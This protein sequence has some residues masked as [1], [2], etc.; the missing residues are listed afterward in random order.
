MSKVAIV[1]DSSAYIPE[2]LLEQYNISVAPLVVIWGEDEYLDNVDIQP[3]EL[4]ERLNNSDVMPSTSQATP[5]SFMEAY[6]PLYEQGY[7]IL[8]IHLSEKL[9]GTIPSAVQAKGMLP[10]DATIEIIDSYTIAM[11]LGYQVLLVARAVTDGAS[12][13]ECKEIVLKARSMCGV[14][15]AVD[16]L[17]FLHRGGRIGGASKF[18]GTALNIKPILEVTD[19]K[20]ESI[21]RVRTR[22]KSIARLVDLVEE[23][24]QGRQP[25]RLAAL[26]ANAEDDARAC[27]KVAADQLGATETI[28]TSVSPAIGVHT[29]P[30]TVGLAYL[31]GM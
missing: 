18:L 17:E 15:F 21:E 4:Y 16:T 10:D 19:G 3:N 28:F 11:A 27:L 29:G 8:S 20:I 31:A 30:G 12:L 22:K 7:E 14:V 6:T 26:H 2:N 1:T 9:S 5:R 25:V 24:I 23:R 13:A